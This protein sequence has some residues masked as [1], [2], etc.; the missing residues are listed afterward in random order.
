MCWVSTEK[1]KQE[2][3]PLMLS[4]QGTKLSL[5]MLAGSKSPWREKVRY[6]TPAN[7]SQLEGDDTYRGLL[8]CIGWLIRFQTWVRLTY[9][10]G[11]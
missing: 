8:I 10:M 4:A 9:T 7:S 5:A 6:H 3:K 11:P 2:V 1:R